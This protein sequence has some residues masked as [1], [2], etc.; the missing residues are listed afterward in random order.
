MTLSLFSKYTFN[1][2]MK[3][4]S[5]TFAALASPLVHGSEITPM[6]YNQAVENIQE[7]LKEYRS[8]DGALCDSFTCCNVTATES[9]DLKDMPKDETTLVLPGMKS[10]D[11][12]DLQS[13]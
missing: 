5:I 3:V 9:C 13:G 4:S 8:S 10:R 6:G 7:N 11:V 2:A 12:L 1:H